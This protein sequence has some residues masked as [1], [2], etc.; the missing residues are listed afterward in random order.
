MGTDDELWMEEALRE[1]QRGFALGEV[2]VGAVVVCDGRVIGRGANRPISSSDPTAHAE[3][4]A[5]RE[6]GQQLGNY[7]LSGCDL[8]VTIEPCAMC[9][10]AITH[11]RI[12]RLVYGA[13]DAK[14][15][16]VKSVMQ[17]LN[18]PQLNHR[19]E[20]VSG[21]LAS[22]AMEM[23]QAFFRERRTK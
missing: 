18:H 3:I 22:R 11:A 21:V 7:R 5:L 20:V 23:V 12:R 2:P 1:A 14:A 17:V 13:D 16:A 19:V 6:A 9:A 8:Y 4:L 10:G 15:G